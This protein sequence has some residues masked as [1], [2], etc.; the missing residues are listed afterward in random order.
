MLIVVSNSE[1]EPDSRIVPPSRQDTGST[2]HISA[3]APN[4]FAKQPV[5]SWG[6]RGDLLSSSGSDTMLIRRPTPETAEQ[7]SHTTPPPTY[8]T[9]S[10]ILTL[11]IGGPSSKALITSDRRPTP[12][13]RESQGTFDSAAK[14]KLSDYYRGS[15]LLRFLIWR[16]GQRSRAFHPWWTISLWSKRGA[17]RRRLWVCWQ[18]TQFPESKS[19]AR[20][21]FRRGKWIRKEDLRS[22]KTEL[23]VPRQ[24]HHIHCV[25]LVGIPAFRLLARSRLLIHENLF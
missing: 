18:G 22:F 7:E 1:S 15:F 17:R 2:P 9:H 10:N 19:V 5:V 8:Q 11:S 12:T 25:E 21:R 3:Q 20:K 23:E 14:T 24:I 6:I 16:E 13:V 4:S